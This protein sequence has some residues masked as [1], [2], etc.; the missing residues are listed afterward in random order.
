MKKHTF[1]LYH[2]LIIAVL[3][4]SACTTEEKR[5]EKN[6]KLQSVEETT[7]ENFYEK[8]FIKN[9]KKGKV[10]YLKDIIS[11]EEN[12]VRLLGCKQDGR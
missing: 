12:D 1:S 5:Q 4:F 11:D 10:E 3:A 9:T 8:F 7:F 2:L 6:E